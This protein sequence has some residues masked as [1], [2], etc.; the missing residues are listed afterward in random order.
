MSKKKIPN[1]H[2]EDHER[3]LRS[4]TTRARRCKEKGIDMQ[5]QHSPRVLSR[6][7]RT[8]AALLIVAGMTGFVVAGPPSWPQFRGPGGLPSAPDARIPDEFGPRHNVRWQREVP[9]GHSSPAI[10]GNRLFLTGFE[11][12][13]LLVLCYRRSDG[14]LLWKREFAMG[15]TDEFVHRDATPAAPT[16]ATNGTRVHAYFGSYGLI[17][18]NMKGKLLW[19][20]KFPFEVSEFGTGSMNRSTPSPTKVA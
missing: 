15:G 6:T 7:S 20:R 13:T 14:K 5:T 19:E 9:Q 8:L 16:P 1:F 18:L 3:E 4:K 17:T 12:S 10:W 11:D 2:S